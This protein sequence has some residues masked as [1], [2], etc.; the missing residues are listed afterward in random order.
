LFELSTHGSLGLIQLADNLLIDKSNTSRTV[1]QLVTLG[2]V[3]SKKTS[4]DNRQKSFRLTA[5]GKKALKATISLADDQ[6]ESALANLTPEQHQV[7]VQGLQLYGQALRKSRLQSEFTIRPIRK[8][9]SPHVAKVIRD[10][11]TEFDAVGEGY[12]INDEEVDTMYTSYREKSSCYFVIEREDKIVGGGG[13]GPLAGGTKSIC[14]LRKMFFRPIARG[15]G[16]GQ[17]LLTLLLTEA[18]KRGFK[19]CYLETLDRMEAA[20][21]LYRRNGF[22]AIDGA[23]G[24]TGHCSCDSYYLLKL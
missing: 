13:I 7:V 17:K 12:S 24:N 5:N 21:A 14:E 9:D 16:L 23:M 19:K 1:K 11:M 22:E 20:N 10:V 8:S 3:E 2:L 6:V 18:R 4:T 15:F